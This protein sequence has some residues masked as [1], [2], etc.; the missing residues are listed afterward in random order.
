MRT[1]EQC[2][3]K[4]INLLQQRDERGREPGKH[5]GYNLRKDAST[6]ATAKPKLTS[7]DEKVVRGVQETRKKSREAHAKRRNKWREVVKPGATG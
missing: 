1:K 3:S 6:T 4:A 7:R 5:A 2:T